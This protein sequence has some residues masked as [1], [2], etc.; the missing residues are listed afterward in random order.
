MK[1]ISVYFLAFL[2]NSACMMPHL[3]C[4]T[5]SLTTMYLQDPIHSNQGSESIDISSYLFGRDKKRRLQATTS[6]FKQSGFYVHKTMS[7]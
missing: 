4:V 3:L 2:R 1:I 6:L 5:I 7:F